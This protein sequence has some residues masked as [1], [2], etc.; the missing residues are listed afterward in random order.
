MSKKLSSFSEAQTMPGALVASSLNP[1]WDAPGTHLLGIIGSPTKGQVSRHCFL[2]AW[3]MEDR[4][5]CL[6]FAEW[7]TAGSL[8]RPVMPSCASFGHD[9]HPACPCPCHAQNVSCDQKHAGLSTQRILF[10]GI[11]GSGWEARD[12]QARTQQSPCHSL[13]KRGR[14]PGG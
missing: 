3:D 6:P 14:S 8:R 1:V 4:K 11:E 9:I 7:G 12:S 5:C 13:G 2:G 10:Q